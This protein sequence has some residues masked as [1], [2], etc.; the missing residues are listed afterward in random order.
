MAG[1]K[2][3]PRKVSLAALRE[4]TADIGAITEEATSAFEDAARRA[5]AAHGDPASWTKEGRDSIREEMA[6]LMD[7]FVSTYGDATQSLAAAAFER[8]LEGQGADADVPMADVDVAPRA[9]ASARYWAS[10]LWGEAPD[11]EGFV[12][13]C[14]SFVERHVRHSADY[15]VISAADGGAWRGR[16]HYARVPQGPSCG[17]CIM[18]A[19]RGFVYVTPES[20]GEFSKFHDGCDCLVVA[21][22][23]GIDVEGYDYEGMRERYRMCREAL[24]DPEDVWE[25]FKGLPREEKDRYGRGPR[26]DMADLP[27]SLVAEIGGNAN[28]FN[29]YYA[30][31]IVNEMDTRDKRWL[32]DGTL[33]ETDYIK[34]REALSDNE[35]AGVDYLRSRG[36]RM[37]VIPEDPTANMNLDL[38]INGVG[39]EMRN[40]TNSGSSVDNQMKRARIKWMKAGSGSMLLIATCEGCTDSYYSVL[41]RVVEKLRPGEE[42]YVISD[43]GGR[44]RHLRK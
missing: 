9:K 22:L 42:A 24:G 26:A 19:S 33:P 1:E 32:Y 21:G 43:G 28:A 2:G 16:I 31:R 44:L 3:G 4:Y 13:G 14:A 18:L 20:A 30:K 40:I 38:S 29:D 37:S 23:E 36:F 6:D 34:P 39:W 35:R 15:C 12:A 7:G 17:F 27:E 25:E 5:I 41:R 10:R 8:V 11:V